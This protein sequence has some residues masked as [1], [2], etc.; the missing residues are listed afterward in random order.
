MA[1]HVCPMCVMIAGYRWV[2]INYK[3]FVNAR[4]PTLLEF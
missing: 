3:Q 1:L 4:R 2:V